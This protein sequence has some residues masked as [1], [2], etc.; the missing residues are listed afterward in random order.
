MP[1]LTES[2]QGRDLG[3]L[4][5]IAELWGSE[6]EEQEIQLGDPSSKYFAL[7]PTGG[8][9]HGAQ[10]CPTEVKTALDG[11]NPAFEAGCHGHNLPALTVKCV[12]WVRQSAT[13]SV[14][15]NSLYQQLK[16]CGIA[17]S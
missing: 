16:R 3:H 9:R 10:A 7:K 4:R 6:L 14:H 2:L 15:T 17:P 11:A 8:E 5:I 12:R 13:V 1:D